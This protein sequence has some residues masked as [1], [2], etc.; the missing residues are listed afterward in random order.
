MVKAFDQ[1]VT[2][3]LT[4]LKQ[5]IASDTKPASG[6]QVAAILAITL[7]PLSVCVLLPVGIVALIIAAVIWRQ[8]QPLRERVRL[9]IQPLREQ[10]RL[11]NEENDRRQ[12][13][14]AKQVTE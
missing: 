6:W 12:R 4:S 10:V 7:L 13:K 3:A 9:A 5:F 11:A 1:V 2:M 14:V 8:I